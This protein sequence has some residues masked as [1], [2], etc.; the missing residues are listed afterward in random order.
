MAGKKEIKHTVKKGDTLWDLAKKY[1]GSGN[2]WNEI[3][4]LNKGSA[5]NQI[6]DPHWIYP[7][8]VFIIQ[9]GD[10]VV[11]VAKPKPAPKPATPSPAKKK[12]EPLVLSYENRYNKTKEL[13]NLQHDPSQ[14]K[15]IDFKQD[16]TVLIRKK[17]YYAVNQ[18]D[19]EKYVKVFQINNFMQLRTA[20]SVHGKGSASITI[21]GGERIVV[22]DKKTA[23]DLSGF[24]KFKDLLNHWNSL[25]HETAGKEW[26]GVEYNSTMKVREHKYGWAIAEKCD[27]EPMDEVYIFSKSRVR[28]KAGYYP[29]KQIFFGYV[30]G[31]TKSYTA[32]QSGAVVSIQVDDHL[33]LL[34]I[35]RVANRPALDY[36]TITP[37]SR[38]DGHGFWVLEDDFR[39]NGIDPDTLEPLSSAPG[40]V[41]TNS[42]AGL[43]AHKII[44]RLCLEAGIPH[45]KI[46]DRVEEIERTP[47]AI[48]MGANF[49]NVFSGDFEKRLTYCQKAANVMNFE[50]FADEE[51]N[52][53]FKIP[54]WNIGIN[55]KV[56]NNL[57]HDFAYLYD[58]G[59]ELHRENI[60]GK[61]E[62]ETKKVTKTKKVQETT[63]TEV[64][65]TVVKGDTLWDIS[66]KYLG[67]PTKW[68]NIYKDNKSKIKDPHWIYPGQKFLIKKGVTKT[69][70]KKY[71]ETVKVPK[72]SA[73]ADFKDAG[74]IAKITDKLIP[75]VY[76]HEII[77]FSFT[78]SDRDIFTAAEVT[79]EPSYIGAAMTAI[80]VASRRAVQDPGL[81]AKFGVRVAP[82]ITTPLVG[83][84]KG[85]EIYANLLIIKSLSNRYTG[86]LQMIEEATI[87]VGD[88][89]RF[90]VYD[91]MPFQELYARDDKNMNSEKNAQAVF[92]V[93]QIDRSIQINGVSTMNLALTGG[94][95]MGMPSL[96]DSATELYRPFFDMEADLSPAPEDPKV[97]QATK[98]YKVVKGDSLSK[99]AAKQMGDGTKWKLLY[100]AN[101]KDMKKGP[102]TS[103][104]R[105]YP[106]Q[107]LKIP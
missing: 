30:T 52:I 18:E 23:T 5:K 11:Q 84:A 86:T 91:E 37:A 16:Y 102:V 3:Y 95:M 63:T 100:E 25:N 4:K 13:D 49:D 94:R 68:P 106:G 38:L 42:F 58:V 27:I 79:A 19:D 29:F 36:S 14:M 85:A 44:Q 43:D 103:D 6:K 53:V 62:F 7:G 35:S 89:I 90:N 48:Q 39:Y 60:S 22:A 72:D 41:F 26:N 88:P 93:E 101:R 21:K 8:Q 80:P 33:K 2:K 31:V 82:P 81:I 1:L 47:F 12:I 15:I 57:G 92:Y 67:S 17:L 74:S 32:G 83:G 9:K 87:R 24:D 34:D 73:P 104:Y 75:V 98:T 97:K 78:D 99:I 28:D 59:G 50:F 70:E 105:I 77:S 20:N 40:F 10:P 55:R 66:A 54:S 96:F 45:S 71:T 69:V 46:K 65:H 61:Q 76:P 56:K 64:W 107:V 51:G